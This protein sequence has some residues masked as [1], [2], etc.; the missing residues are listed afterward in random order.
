MFHNQLACL[1]Q[2]GDA[3]AVQCADDLETWHGKQCERHDDV[4]NK[5]SKMTAMSRLLFQR[6]MDAHPQL[7]MIHAQAARTEALL[8][9]LQALTA[10]DD[11]FCALVTCLYKLDSADIDC[12]ARELQ[13][14]DR[15][16]SMH[17]RALMA[18]LRTCADELQSA[19]SIIEGDSS[20]DSD[21]STAPFLPTAD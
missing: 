7:D 18:D 6:D 9:E 13:R 16:M 10:P 3:I 17:A 4:H 19:I 8:L 2:L 20:S 15:G 12:C 21:D 14:W 1:R 11:T 5:L